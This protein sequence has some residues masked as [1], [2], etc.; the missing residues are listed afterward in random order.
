MPNHTYACGSCGGGGLVPATNC[1][2]KHG[3]VHTCSPRACPRCNGT[4][5]LKGGR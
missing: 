3:S 1:Q 4:G 2:C 5:W